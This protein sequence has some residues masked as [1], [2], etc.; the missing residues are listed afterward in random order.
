ML[1]SDAGL[2]RAAGSVGLL[3]RGS[4]SAWS[5]SAQPGTSLASAAACKV[6]E[7]RRECWELP[8]AAAMVQGVVRPCPPSC[9][10]WSV[11]RAWQ[12]WL[13]WGR[14]LQS[15][16]AGGQE[17]FLPAAFPWPRW[18]PRLEKST[19]GRREEAVGSLCAPQLFWMQ[20]P[21]HCVSQGT[22]KI[23]TRKKVCV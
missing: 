20:L 2:V 9:P 3:R 11:E 6:L 23:L 13:G 16:R 1:C 12:I 10:A 7:P 8:V 14:L 21:S 17:R 22:K 5:V 18:A 15:S 19:G 4:C